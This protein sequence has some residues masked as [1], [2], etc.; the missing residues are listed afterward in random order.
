M[1]K[2]IKQIA[3][4]IGADVCGI[5]SID[6]FDNFPDGFSPKDIW[7]QCKSVISIGIALPKGLFDINSR[8]I[9]GYY[10][11][12]LCTKVDEMLFK[13]SKEIEEQFACHA[14]PLPCNTPYEYWDAEKLTGK[15]LLSMK[16]VGEACGLG[17]IGKSTLLLNRKFGNRLVLGAVLTNLTL[18]SDPLETGICVSTCSIC[19]DNCPVN[20]IKDG[21]V[22]Q[23]LCRP[24]AYGKTERGFNTTDCNL[25]RAFCPH[26]L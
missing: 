18:Q 21:Y 24:Y 14:I 6:R 19:K 2:E 8:L 12:M 23:K 13:L 16:H 11:E 25:C 10:N 3:Y 22:D 26:A 9:Y 1:E 15:G 4:D 17:E 7:L 5:G 20:A